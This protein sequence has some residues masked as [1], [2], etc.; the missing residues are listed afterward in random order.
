MITA[1]KARVT[2]INGRHL[3]EPLVFG[4]CC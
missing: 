1:H 3:E 2:K 4:R